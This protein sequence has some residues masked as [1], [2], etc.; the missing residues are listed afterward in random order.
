MARQRSIG[1]AIL[2]SA[3][4]VTTQVEMHHGRQEQQR[5]ADEVV[6]QH[7]GQRGG[8]QG[9]RE[10]AGVEHGVRQSHAAL[11]AGLILDVA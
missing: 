8:Q 5:L 6:E 9:E 1:P 3:T 7:A 2:T 4:V 11:L 10:A